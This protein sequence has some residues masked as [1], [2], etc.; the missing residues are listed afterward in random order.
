MT[1]NRERITH[2]EGARKNSDKVYSHNKKWVGKNREKSRAIKSRWKKAHRH[3]SEFRKKEYARGVAWRAEISVIEC[4]KCGSKEQLQRHHLDYN[5]PLEVV[6]L[7]RPCH[8]RE[9]KERRG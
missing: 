5:K 6:I 3:D 9:H 1:T 8:I 7:C 4:I 2:R